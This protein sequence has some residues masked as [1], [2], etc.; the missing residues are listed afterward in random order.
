MALRAGRQAVSR[1]QPQV[2]RVTGSSYGGGE[3]WLQRAGRTGLFERGDRRRATRAGAPGRS[4]E[5][6]WDR[7]CL[8]PCPNGRRVFEAVRDGKLSYTNSS[9]PRHPGRAFDPLVTP[10]VRLADH[11]RSLRGRRCRGPGRRTGEAR[12]HG[13]TELLLRRTW[14]VQAA[15]RKTAIF[16]TGLDGRPLHSRRGV[17]AVRV[18]Q[19][20]RPRWPLRWRSRVGHPRARGKAGT[21]L[22]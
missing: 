3:S 17:A 20:T 6:R 2:G 15:G 10:E 9:L 18:S 8:Q 11:R 19:T 22:G 16:G 4:A 1:H 13:G 7:P 5:V 21:W 12:P 14:G